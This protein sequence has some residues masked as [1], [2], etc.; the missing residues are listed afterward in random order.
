[1]T[2]KPK[3]QRPLATRAVTE[4]SA[5]RERHGE[6]PPGELARAAEETG[7]SERHLRRLLT[8]A[9]AADAGADTPAATPARPYPV[10]DQVRLAVHRASGNIA[11]AHGL[12]AKQR[13]VPSIRTL[14][15]RIASEMTSAERAFARHGSPGLRSAQQ[16][17]HADYGGRL[18]TVQLDHTQLPVL[19]VPRGHKRAHKPWITA[20]MDSSTRYPLSWVITF[21]SP[22]A[23]QIRAAFIQAMLMRPAP[24]GV[25]WVG[26]RPG[27][28]IC[29]RGKDFLSAVVAQSCLR[30]GVHCHALPGY[31][32]HL[33]GRLERF[34][35]F[36]K[37]NFL[38]PLPG[39]L[40]GPHDIRG[41]AL[42]A[43]AALGE[44][45]F[46]ERL[47]QWMDW[48]TTEHVNSSTGLTA[49][50]MW[51]QDATPITAIAPE[52][53]WQDFLLSSKH[54]VG[55]EGIRFERIYYKVIDPKRPVNNGQTVE[56]RHLPH[57]RS[58]IEVFRDGEH[59]GTGYPSELLTPDQEQQFLHTRAQQ[60]QAALA[61]YTVANNLRS[62]QPGAGRVG[63]DDTADHPQPPGRDL[64]SGG[65]EAL[66]RLL[67]PNDD[68]NR[69]F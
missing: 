40:D 29:D 9:T 59:L 24:D 68:P 27:N 38:A 49:L 14:R 44:D 53:L 17:L 8:R 60:R 56:V 28:A 50:Q 20:V 11:V 51:Q 54:K 22:N 63:T 57:D 13:P 33:K 18:D 25:T 58:F 10:D 21:G 30:L 3:I 4:L 69:M 32:P 62:R 1:M 35:R 66:Q 2:N 6:L 15:R 64:F 47:A 52:R 65:H 23:D 48:Y 12:L 31:S 45:D 37:S 46:V 41:K 7:Y 26:G 36:L 67:H 5:L 19:V 39:Y 61:R 16:Y 42:F 43:G 55:K 34:W